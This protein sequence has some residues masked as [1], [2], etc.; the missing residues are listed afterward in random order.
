[1]ADAVSSPLSFRDFIRHLLPTATALCLF[2]PL[3]HFPKEKL[4]VA[5]V[6]FA[7][8]ILGYLVTTPL[9][10]F[11]SRYYDSTPIMKV[12]GRR[13][14]WMKGNW[15]LDKLF[16]SLTQE[17]RDYI[18]VTAGYLELYRQLSFYLSIYAAVNL[19]VLL[20]AIQGASDVNSF[21]LRAVDARTTVVGGLLFPTA[22]LF[23]ISLILAYYA[24]KDFLN[25][26]AILFHDSGQYSIFAGRAHE[27]EGGLAKSISGV[28]LNKAKPLR[29]GKVTLENCRGTTLET[30]STDL[31][32]YFQFD[33]KS[34]KHSAGEYKLCIEDGETI[35]M[36]LLPK[37][38]PFFK[39]E[40][41]RASADEP[42]LKPTREIKILAVGIVLFEILSVFV[43]TEWRLKVLYTLSIFPFVALILI[44]FF[45]PTKLESPILSASIIL[46]VILV[47]TGV[48]NSILTFASLGSNQALRWTNLVLPFLTQR[49]YEA[50]ILTTLVFLMYL[51]SSTEFEI[52]TSEITRN[53]GLPSLS[54]D[55]PKFDRKP[56]A[57][58]V[59][60]Q[61]YVMT[62]LG[63]NLQEISLSV[64]ESAIGKI[65][66]PGPKSQPD[67]LGISATFTIKVLKG[68]NEGS[69]EL[70]LS[71]ELPKVKFLVEAQ[72]PPEGLQLFYDADGKGSPPVFSDH[73]QNVTLLIRGENL[74]GARLS[75][76]AKFT[77]VDVQ[78]ISSKELRATVTIAAG[79]PVS[80]GYSFEVKN[81]NETP[82]IIEFA[83]QAGGGS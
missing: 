56:L 1:M 44:F 9:N 45:R 61:E 49:W 31:D 7:A 52:A 78:N 19:S 54:P 39:V 22:V 17:E 15:D 32:G 63:E 60:D 29:G 34:G 35:P 20:N 3:F 43:E 40:S 76:P 42:G 62:L 81:S 53:A 72:P 80:E 70:P 46:S 73:D 50:V 21:F 2:L 23:L 5:A 26:Y 47:M 71:V 69:Y 65:D 67:L 27:K 48:L 68:A 18:Y 8:V 28:I 38:T 59:N 12:F 74:N 36:S 41:S 82:A 4:E 58:P 11:L 64:P 14:Q 6:V 66:I 55:G 10:T 24:F 25:E 33:N 83:I 13:W 30:R 75:F 51:T 16:Y 77:I 57:D 37:Q 79:T